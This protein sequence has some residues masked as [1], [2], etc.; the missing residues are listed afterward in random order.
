MKTIPLTQGQV[1]IVDD[2]DYERVAR[3]TWCLHRSGNGKLYA[4]RITRVRGRRRKVKLHR[5]L[6]RCRPGQLGDHRNGDG[7]DNRRRNLRRATH[8]QNNQNKKGWSAFGLKGV[9]RWPNGRWRARIGY[10]GRQRW[11]GMFDDRT[12]A[13]KAYDRAARKMFGEF[14]RLNFP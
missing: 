7:L 8:A 6:L 14:A 13:A 3:F 11:L 10:H 1:A 4:G 5:Y 12:E 2:E 9:S